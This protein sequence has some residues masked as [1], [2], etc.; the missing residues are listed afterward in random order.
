MNFQ[1]TEATLRLQRSLQWH[2]HHSV[3]AKRCLKVHSRL[4][5]TLDMCVARVYR[6]A[7]RQ[8]L[9]ACYQ[10]TRLAAN[11]QLYLTH[12]R[13]AEV[14][15]GRSLEDARVLRDGDAASFGAY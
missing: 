11:Q 6:P 1:D 9:S 5:R 15:T 7:L 8:G 12:D 13:G 4:Q 2:E 3:D 10:A 14:P